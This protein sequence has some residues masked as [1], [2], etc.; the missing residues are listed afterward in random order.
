MKVYSVKLTND[1]T[2][3]YTDKDSVVEYSNRGIFFRKK[4]KNREVFYPYSN[5]VYVVEEEEDESAGR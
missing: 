4:E 3:T 2:H 1:F 5:V